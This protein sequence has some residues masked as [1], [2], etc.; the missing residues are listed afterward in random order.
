MPQ[1]GAMAD[2]QH[3]AVAVAGQVDHLKGAGGVARDHRGMLVVDAVRRAPVDVRRQHAAELRG[4]GRHQQVEVTVAIHVGD[5]QQDAGRVGAVVLA[6]FL[7]VAVRAAVQD[8]EP[9]VHARVVPHDDH[10]QV[11]PAVTGQVGAVDRGDVAVAAQVQGDA[12]HPLG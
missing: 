4:I 11:Q 8:V 1:V 5:G 12:A 6:P 10:D 7:T 2:G 3:V 9:R